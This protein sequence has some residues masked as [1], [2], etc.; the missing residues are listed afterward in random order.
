MAMGKK[1]IASILY[2]AAWVLIW[3]TVGSLIDFPLLQSGLYLK[4]S[5]GQITTF[6]VTA[7]FSS[8]LGTWLFSYMLPLLLI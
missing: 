4:G 2:V 1:E 8:I 5:I 3:G 6:L 7:V